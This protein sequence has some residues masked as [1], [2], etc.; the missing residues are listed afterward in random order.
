MQLNLPK[1]NSQFLSI[2]LLILTHV[3]QNC[4]LRLHVISRKVCIRNKAIDI[5]KLIQS[6]ANL[7]PPHLR[8]TEITTKFF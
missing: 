1:Y 8:S 7:G 3:V 6:L 4:I 2:G 5:R